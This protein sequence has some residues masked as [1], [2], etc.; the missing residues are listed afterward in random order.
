MMRLPKFRYVSAKS[1]AEVVHLLHE[2]GP[3]AMVLAGGTDL[4]PNM[5]RRQQTPKVVIG[6]KKVQELYTRKRQGGEL[7][8]GSMLN[9]AHVSQDNFVQEQFG[10]LYKAA[11]QVATPQLRNMGTL[12]GNL[13]LDTRCNYYDQNYEWRKAINFC[14]KK[15][16]EICWVAP[17]SS[18]C[19]AVSSTDT[20]PALIA[21][22]A[23]V[24]L[25]S[26]DGERFL[27]LDELYEDDG[28]N[29][30]TKKRDELL[31]EILIPDGQGWKSTYWKLR[32][33]GSFDFSILSVA[34]A[35]K[36]KKEIVE[37]A[38]VVL[39]ALAS[40]PVWV[41]ELSQFLQGKSLS[42]E[43]ISQAADLAWKP[44]KPVDNTDFNLAWRKKMVRR[45]V[46]G[47][48]KELRGDPVTDIM[49]RS[50]RTELASDRCWIS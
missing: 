7:V 35:L 15:D 21:L 14:M 48:L 39:G 50:T 29:Y 25:V 47:A 41:K 6:L 44:A 28:M 4:F 45:F 19:W 43:N 12:G 49:L 30:L 46:I 17:S 10:A 8:L 18:K 38:R 11:V 24:R 9:L 23:R 26:K 5:K 22:G 1:V 3:Q 27:N 40:R 32:R 13:C 2:E 34:A 36:R 37:D 16:G 42:D 31:T 20:A 33:R